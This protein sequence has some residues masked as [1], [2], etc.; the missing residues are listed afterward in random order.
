MTLI[1][2]GNVRLSPIDYLSRRPPPFTLLYLSPIVYPGTRAATEVY[3]SYCIRFKQ[4]L[5]NKPV[6]FETFNVRIN[7][8]LNDTQKKTDKQGKAVK[9][10]LKVFKVG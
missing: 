1:K 5:D 3:I 7:N 2:Q 10:Y 8:N 6:D 9:K 4:Y